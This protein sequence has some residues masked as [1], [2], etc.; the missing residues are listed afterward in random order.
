MRQDMALI[1]WTGSCYCENKDV[2]G[3][4]HRLFVFNGTGANSVALQAVTR[5][6]SSICVLKQLHISVTS[7]ASPV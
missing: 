4:M 1:D 5:P 3:E 6:F 7:V 2:F